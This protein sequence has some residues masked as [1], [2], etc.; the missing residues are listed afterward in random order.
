MQCRK[1]KPKKEH[2]QRIAQDF[3]KLP[4]YKVPLQATD[5]QG[6]SALQH[7]A[8]LLEQAGL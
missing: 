1:A 6:L 5:I 8:T 4:L 7:M 3:S 2:L